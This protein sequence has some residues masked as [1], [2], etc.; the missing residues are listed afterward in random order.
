MFVVV[1]SNEKKCDFF[2]SMCEKER[3]E[4]KSISV[5][6][7]EECVLCNMVKKRGD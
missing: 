2:A 5:V 7:E 1:C 3:Q 6:G 4:R